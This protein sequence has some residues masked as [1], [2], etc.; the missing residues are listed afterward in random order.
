MEQYTSYRDEDLCI[1]L[2]SKDYGA[3]AEIYERYWYHLLPYAIRTLKDS[4]AAEDVVQDVFV[5]LWSKA[6]S[7][8]I[9]KL[10]TFLYTATRNRILLSFEKSKVRQKYLDSLS[11]YIEEENEIPDRKVLEKELEER[12]AKAIDLLPTKMKEIFILRQDALSYKDISQKL[13]TS[14]DNVRKQL[15]NARNILRNKL[16]SLLFILF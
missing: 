5:S 1:L 8:E 7:L 4:A 13:G 11:N 14:E 3:Y 16:T 15:N 9:K 12:I 10:S 6:D 2:K